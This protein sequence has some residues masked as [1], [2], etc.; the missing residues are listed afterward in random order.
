MAELQSR[1]LIL[2]NNSINAKLVA[3]ILGQIGLES[4]VLNSA[5]SFFDTLAEDNF[6]LIFIDVSAPFV[7]GCRILEA[8]SK[9]P[10]YKDIPIIF[11]SEMSDIKNIVKELDFSFYDYISKSCLKAELQFKTKNILLL[12]Q[13]QEERDC[14]IETLT[15]DL[16]TPVRSEIRAMELLLNGH[17]GVLNPTQLEV[18]EE[19]LNS[20]NYMFFMLDAMLSKYNLDKNKIKLLPTDFSL[21]ELIQD[22]IREVRVLFETKKQN[23]ILCF[24]NEQEQINA[25][26]MAIKRIVM[27]LLSNAIKFSPEKSN[28]EI[29]VFDNSEEI[30]ISFIDNGIGIA[31]NDLKN[32]FKY[33]VKNKKR[34]KQVGSGL[35]LYISKKIIEMHGGDII[36]KSHQGQ[37]SNFIISLPKSKVSLKKKF[38]MSK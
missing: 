26:Y 25:D 31:G 3:E 23:V 33:Q 19:I 27:N 18:L 9:S 22:C 2:E 7:N 35:G 12:K 38:A 13:L 8:L 5:K 4:K 17:F 16:K 1:A 28:I 6:D 24:E 30:G 21:N 20:S 36:A 32:I 10:L 11:L 15:H 29:R 14:F 37:G 34:F